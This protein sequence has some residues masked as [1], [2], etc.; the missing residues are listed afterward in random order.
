MHHILVDFENVHHVDLSLIGARAVSFTLMV[1]AKQTKLDAG[2]VEKLMAHSSSVQLVKLKAAGKN[3][4]DFALAYYLGRAALAD[5]T[6]HFHIIAKDTGYDPLIQHLRERHIDVCRHESCPD[7]PF[8]SPGKA[9]TTSKPVAEKPAAKAAVKKA[10]KA[11][12]MPAAKKEDTMEKQMELVVRNF[13]QHPKA[14]PA[15]RK[16]LL[17]KVAD[18]IKRPVASQEVLSVI[19]GMQKAGYLKFNEKDVPSYPQSEL[20][21]G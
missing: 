19:E 12:T 16:T 8:F 6:A 4:L 10:T 17:A 7:L 1:G 18:L 9:I 14:R 3:A 2:L 11:Q 13:T 5:P 20:R 21:P 15:K